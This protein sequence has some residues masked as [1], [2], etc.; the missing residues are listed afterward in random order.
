MDAT[1]GFKQTRPF[2][3]R[4]RT[5]SGVPLALTNPPATV[6]EALG[7]IEAG[8]RGSNSSATTKFGAGR[9]DRNGDYK[10][11]PFIETAVSSFAL[12]HHLADSL[13]SAAAIADARESAAGEPSSNLS[14]SRAR[15]RVPGTPS[16]AGPI[17]WGVGDEAGV[18]M[19]G[20]PPFS[21]QQGCAGMY[22]FRGA[23]WAK[24]IFKRKRQGQKQKTRESSC[25][26]FLRGRKF[27]YSPLQLY[28]TKC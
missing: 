15:V 1:T 17:A 22:T 6:N 27:P 21:T 2:A 5:L 25:A 8:N 4:V 19:G 24:Q 20:N 3:E 16:G 12:D 28:T 10:L 11:F 23:Y 7:R 18:R 14:P 13:A 26:L 9:L